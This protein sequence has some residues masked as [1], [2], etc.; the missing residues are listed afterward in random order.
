[1]SDR[2]T[3]AEAAKLLG[4]TT[5]RIRALLDER[6][7]TGKRFGRDWQVDRASVMARKAAKRRGKLSK[8][9]AGMHRP[10]SE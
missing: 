3:T 10:K 9:G 6:L 5:T 1:M 2:I 4:V 8:G 7:L